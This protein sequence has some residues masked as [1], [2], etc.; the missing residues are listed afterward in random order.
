MNI[1]KIFSLFGPIPITAAISVKAGAE[2]QYQ[3]SP[4]SVQPAERIA[5]HPK[6]DRCVKPKCRRLL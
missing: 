1:R 6:H 3:I 5:N 2:D 4:L